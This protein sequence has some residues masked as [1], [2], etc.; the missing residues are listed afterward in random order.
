MQ[1]VLRVGVEIFQ[2]RIEGGL[3]LAHRGLHS[4]VKDPGAGRRADEVDIAAQATPCYGAFDLAR[5]GAVGVGE[6]DAFQR[7][8]DHKQAEEVFGPGLAGGGDVQIAGGKTEFADAFAI[9]VYGGVGVE[10]FGRKGN[11]AA[12]PIRQER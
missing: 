10:V 2:L 9:E 11:A 7:H 6:H 5:G 12:G 1:R 8:G 4:C 3:P